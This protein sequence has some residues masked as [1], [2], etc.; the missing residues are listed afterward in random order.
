VYSWDLICSI[1]VIAL[2]K[3]YCY[4]IIIAIIA[5][6]ILAIFFASLDEPGVEV[7]EIRY[8]SLSVTDL[9]VS[10]YVTLDVDND[11]PIGATLT[12]VE[13]DIYIDDQ[14]IGTSYS[15]KEFDIGANSVSE[16]EVVLEVESVP[17]GVISKSSVEVQVVGTAYLS[18]SFLDFE[19]PIDETQI[20]N[21][22]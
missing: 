1:E 22:G 4:G 11:N 18:V 7:T 2:E 20:V 9:T 21:I 12:A 8:K 17:L 19:V 15:E 5:I 13:A 3:K 16:V 10:F 6:V 14:L